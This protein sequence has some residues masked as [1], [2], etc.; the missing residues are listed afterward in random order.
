MLNIHLLLAFF[1]LFLEIF[2]IAKIIIIHPII[3]IIGGL[4]L[5]P[6]AT[7]KMLITT[8]RYLKQLSN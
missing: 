1:L 5:L 8:I 3:F 4:L 6:Y 7:F 2:V